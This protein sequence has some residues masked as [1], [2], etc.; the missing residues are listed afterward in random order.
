MKNHG[1]I[2]DNLPHVNLND[3]CWG[4]SYF[5]NLVRFKKN[6]LYITGTMTNVFC[7][8]Y[9]NSILEETGDFCAL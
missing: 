8:Q 6:L 5:V 4:K 1:L 7:T 3:I 9:L 2:E